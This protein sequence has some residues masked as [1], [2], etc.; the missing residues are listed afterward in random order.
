MQVH[1]HASAA[2]KQLTGDFDVDPEVGQLNS[3][4]LPSEV[5]HLLTKSPHTKTPGVTQSNSQKLH[6]LQKGVG[7]INVQIHDVQVHV[8][9]HVDVRSDDDELADVVSATTAM[10][11]QLLNEPLD[12][13]EKRFRTEAS[14]VTENKSQRKSTSSLLQVEPLEAKKR[15]STSSEDV[16]PQAVVETDT[17]EKQSQGAL[18]RDPKGTQSNSQQL[19][20]KL[21]NG[22]GQINMQ[23]HDVAVDVNVKVN[24]STND[25]E[26]AEVVQNASNLTN[27]TVN[28]SN[29][30]V[31][32][33]TSLNLMKEGSRAE[34]SGSKEMSQ[35][36]LPQSK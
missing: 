28:S 6:S 34:A 35:S 8:N 18:N 11:S 29:Q 36:K 17:L 27:W 21:Q 14:E 25:D 24:V 5:Q 13:E 12:H 4:E 30:D 10:P 31:H 9:V 1:G 16:K 3:E 2:D 15:M 26:L 7:Q 20:G 33:H 23:V 19:P 22:I 32:W